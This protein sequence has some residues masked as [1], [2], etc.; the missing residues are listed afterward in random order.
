MAE[1]PN[2]RVEG[3]CVELRNLVFP[4]TSS[5]GDSMPT[6]TEASVLLL[7]RTQGENVLSLMLYVNPACFLC[8]FSGSHS[9]RVIKKENKGNLR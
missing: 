5:A 3:G 1:A 7:P 4:L 2:E 6:Q 8:A 9:Q